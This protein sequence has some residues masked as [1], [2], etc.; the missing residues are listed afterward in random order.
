MRRLGL[1]ICAAVALAPAAWAGVQAPAALATQDQSHPPLSIWRVDEQGG[2]QHRQSGLACPGQ[3]RSYKRSATTYYNAF[4]LD[5]SCNYLQPQVSDVTV[6]MTRR[7]GM[8]LDFVIA[9]AKRALLQVRADKHPQL[10]SETHPRSGSLAWDVTSTAWT[11]T[12]T[13]PSGS[14]TWMAGPWNTAPPT[15]STPNRRCWPTWLR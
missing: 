7:T 10:I 12:P 13:T 6:Y 5:V 14:P 3:F 11:A 8:T 9:D 4:G 1:A 15:A 2:L